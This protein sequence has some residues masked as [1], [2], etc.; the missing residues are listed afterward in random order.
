MKINET[1]DYLA[2]LNKKDMTLWGIDLS[3]D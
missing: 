2:F 3:L 1:G